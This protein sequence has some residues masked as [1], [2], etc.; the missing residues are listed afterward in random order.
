MENL[1]NALDGLLR[2]AYRDG[3]RLDC[4]GSHERLREKSA[5]HAPQSRRRIGTR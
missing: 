2:A 3:Y 5:P 1:A 4:L